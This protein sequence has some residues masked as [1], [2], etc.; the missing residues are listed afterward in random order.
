M[1]S[2]G[3]R[4]Y[5][6][7]NSLFLSNVRGQQSSEREACRGLAAPALFDNYSEDKMNE[8]VPTP[9]LFFTG[10]CLQE[11]SVNVNSTGF[12]RG[13]REAKAI[14]SPLLGCLA[15]KSAGVIFLC[16]FLAGFIDFM[17]II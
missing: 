11:E 12:S 1:Q 7:C 8:A 6:I 14:L 13:N 2:S 9:W 10:G 17:P 3:N 5:W 16:R 4:Q 15:A